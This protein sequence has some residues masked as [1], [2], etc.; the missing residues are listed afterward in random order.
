M[1]NSP[2]KFT[3]SMNQEK[4]AKLQA[5][6]R[7]GGK[8]TARRK[9]K[10]VHRTATADDKK[11]Q[12][13]LKKLA[14]NNIAGIEEVNMIKDDGTVIHFNNPK[15]QASL[16][17]NTFAITGHAEAK[18]ITEMLPGILSQLG[19]DSLTSLR[20]LA[21]QFPRQVLD[22]K[23]PKP[24]DIDEE[25]D[26][27]PEDLEVKVRVPGLFTYLLE[28]RK[29]CKDAQG[30]KTGKWGGDPSSS[31]GTEGLPAPG[32]R[33]RGRAGDPRA[34]QGAPG[35]RQPQ[36]AL[37][38]VPYR[39]CPGGRRSPGA[40]AQAS[41]ALSSPPPTVMVP[42]GVLKH[43][44]AED[45]VMVQITAENM[46]ALRQAL[47]EM[48]DFTIT[49]GKAEA[50][51]PQEQ[52]HIQWVDDDKDFNKGA[53]I[54]VLVRGCDLNH[55]RVSVPVSASIQHI[56]LADVEPHPKEHIIPARLHEEETAG[57]QARAH[58]HRL[59]HGGVREALHPA[60]SH[61]LNV[62]L[63][64]KANL[65]APSLGPNMGR[66][67]ANTVSVARGSTKATYLPGYQLDGIILK[68]LYMSE[69]GH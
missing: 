36:A 16:S 24:E 39:S 62:Y 34:A 65:R 21:E 29:R 63:K 47:R 32:R 50:E 20:K 66:W 25:E 49:C 45:G 11:L 17:A 4:L 41:G 61:M 59:R 68:S 23:T 2:K 35:P 44:G 3:N 14:V 33:L 31:V 19:A 7:I 37:P 6:V 1:Q 43:P 28:R 12:S 53:N 57:T 51:D 40:Q 60:Q 67:S 54:A 64:Q 9:K 22:S 13:S 56:I 30:L 15:V 58:R 26:D 48:K 52:I 42:V 38:R 46:D 55:F 10:V 69:S 8:G 27:V 5:Q 18:P